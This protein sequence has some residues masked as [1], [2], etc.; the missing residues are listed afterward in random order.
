MDDQHWEDSVART[1]LR[2]FFFILALLLALALLVASPIGGL[3]LYLSGDLGV[4]RAVRTQ[5]RTFALF[6]SG[7]TRTAADVLEYKL[8]LYAAKKP[9]IV[10]AGS[11]GMGSL[12]DSAFVRPML[13]MAGTADSL[14]SLRASLDAMLQIHKPQVILLALDFWWFSPAWEKNPFALPQK[15]QASAYNMSPQALRLPWQ[16]LLQGNISL[17]QFLFLGFR[18]NRFGM[19]A[20]FASDGYGPDG[21]LYATSTIATPLARDAGFARTLDRQRRHIGE[22]IPQEALSTAHLDALA[23][24]YFRLRGRGIVP[25]VFLAPVAGPVLDAMKAEEGLYPHLFR[26]KSALA[27]RGIELVDTSDPRYFGSS[28]CEFLD[29]MHSGE[30]TALRIV[31]ELTS[32]WNGLLSFLNMEQC[33]RLLTEWKGHAAIQ[34]PLL[35]TFWEQDF[36][37]LQCLKRKPAV[38]Q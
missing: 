11:A 7:L 12:R 35:G 5:T 9:H 17:P 34:Q 24:I 21:S 23:D 30:V 20:Q 32:S 37:G 33:N 4:E 3:W 18:E 25:V 10:L 28:S 2:R 27:E 1:W 22:F 26:L 14:S 29:G 38:L 36:L 16:S 6:G 13:N 8:A 31:R 19:R 15:K